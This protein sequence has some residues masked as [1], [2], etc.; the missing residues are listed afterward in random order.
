MKVNF[1]LRAVL[2]TWTILWIVFLVRQSKRGQY[3]DL[4]NF[5]SGDYGSKVRYILGGDLADLLVFSAQNIPAA[6][7]YDIRGFERF[8]VRE[9]RARYYLWPLYRVEEN[10]DFV[11]VYG[12][13]SPAL[14]GYEEFRSLKGIG[15]IYIRRAV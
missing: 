3:D 7:T 2:L 9:V 5:Y 8:S 12:S 10:P 6:S 11:I 13:S 4:R 1:I 15:K 14:E